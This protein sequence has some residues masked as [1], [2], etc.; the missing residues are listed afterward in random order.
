MERCEICKTEFSTRK[1]VMEITVSSGV[2]TYKVVC[3]DKCEKEWFA[4]ACSICKSRRKVRIQKDGLS[5]CSRCSREL[6]SARKKVKYDN[7]SFEEKTEERCF[8]MGVKKN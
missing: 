5:Y 2:R 4:H 8:A 7:P 6:A 3:S 1:R